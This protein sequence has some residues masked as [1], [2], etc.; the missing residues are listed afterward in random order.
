MLCILV[1]VQYTRRVKGFIL[2]YNE[3][4]ECGCM[5][6][7]YSVPW[8]V[9]AGLIEW[10]GTVGKLPPI[11]LEVRFLSIFSMYASHDSR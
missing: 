5:L 6:L 11:I 8:A 4:V 2:S 1:L 3:Y 10:R 7:L 9:V